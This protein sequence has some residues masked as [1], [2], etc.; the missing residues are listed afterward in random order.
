MQSTFNDFELD[1][2][3]NEPKAKKRCSRRTKIIIGVS[4]A[5]VII[6]IAIVIIIAVSKS[7][8]KKSSSK[9][10]IPE[11]TGENDDDSE[12][13]DKPIDVKISYDKDELRLFNIEQKV[14]S[15]VY[16]ES[17][18]EELISNFKYVC[19]L[20]IK[21]NTNTTIKDD[22]IHEGFFAILSS[23]YHNQT[24]NEDISTQN[25]IQL[26]DIINNRTETPLL[27]IIEEKFYSDISQANSKEKE[28]ENTQPFLKIEFYNNGSYKNIIRPIGLS[29]NNYKQM[30]EFLDIIIPKISNDT[31]INKPFSEKLALL[32]AQRL[33]RLKNNN[34]NKRYLKIRRLNNNN[35]TDNLVVKSN[36]SEDYFD[37]NYE[38]SDERNK[39]DEIEDVNNTAKNKG[40]NT[41][42]IE[43]KKQSLVYMENS[44]IRGS[45]KNSYIHFTLNAENKTNYIFSR[46]FVNLTKQNFLSETDKDIYDSDN[47]LK[48]EDV[49]GQSGHINITNKTKNKYDN[50]EENENITDI[51][52]NINDANSIYSTIDNH[53][54]VNQTYY[55]KKIIDEIYDNYLDKFEYEKSNSTLKILRTLQN[56]LPIKNLSNLEITEMDELS[57]RKLE[58]EENKKY[59]GLKRMSNRKNVFQTN[60]L[61]LDIALGLTNTYIPATG[62]SAIA[63]KLDIGDYKVN[64]QINSFQ[65][66]EPIITE[67]L[68]Q[69][70]FKLLQMMY[71]THLNFDEQNKKYCQ[72]IDSNIKDLLGNELIS[73]NKLGNKYTEIRDY[74]ELI[75]NNIGSFEK[76]IDYFK[77]NIT[78]INNNLN[79]TDNEINLTNYEMILE[80]YINDYLINVT[81]DLN[82]KI[83]Y[84][85]KLILEIKQIIDK[86]SETDLSINEDFYYIIEQIKFFIK[87]NLENILLN[88][89]NE[90]KT[91]FNS[92]IQ[93]QINKIINLNQLNKLEYI[94]KSNKIIDYLFSS[95]EKEYLLS[96]LTNIKT[97]IQNK[98]EILLNRLNYIYD[99]EIKKSNIYNISSLINNITNVEIIKNY[100]KEFKIV[101]EYF[102]DIEK[103]D[104]TINEIITQNIQNFTNIL[105]NSGNYFYEIISN[106]SLHYH[107]K[108]IEAGKLIKNKIKE[109]KINKDLNIKKFHDKYFEDNMF[110]FYNIT[111]EK[112]ILSEESDKN[113]SSFDIDFINS[114]MNTIL[115]YGKKQIDVNF[116]LA[117]E[118]LYE[119]KSFVDECLDDN[120]CEVE[121]IWDYFVNLFS[122][123]DCDYYLNLDFINRLTNMSSYSYQIVIDKIKSDSFLDKIEKYYYSFKKEIE[124][125]EVKIKQFMIDDYNYSYLKNM[126]LE[127]KF[128]FTN[129]KED[130]L[131]KAEKNLTNYGRNIKD[132]FLFQFYKFNNRKKGFLKGEDHDVEIEGFFWNDEYKCKNRNNYKYLK[133]SSKNI[134]NHLEDDRIYLTN[135]IM[136]KISQYKNYYDKYYQDL[137][138]GIEIKSNEINFD[139]INLYF[140]M[141]EY[142]LEIKNYL[143]NITNNEFITNIINKHQNCLDN[144]ETIIKHLEIL[145][146]TKQNLI[147]KYNNISFIMENENIDEKIEM[148]NY[149][150]YSKEMSLNHFIIFIENFINSNIDLIEYLNNKILNYIEANLNQEENQNETNIIQTEFDK[151]KKMINDSKGEFKDNINNIL[152]YY[153]NISN[154]FNIIYNIKNYSEIYNNI[155]ESNQTDNYENKLISN[156]IKGMKIHKEI[157]KVSNIIFNT[158][159]SLD[160]NN[161]FFSYVDKNNINM[162]YE[163]VKL[164]IENEA[165]KIMN[166]FVK[167]SLY[168]TQKKFTLDIINE[169]DNFIKDKNFNDTLEEFNN[170]IFKIDG[171][172]S[173]ELEGELNNLYQQLFYLINKSINLNNNKN[174][175]NLENENKTYYI[176][177]LNFINKV[178]IEGLN[179]R[180]LDDNN[181]SE[182]KEILFVL[183]KRF[184][185]KKINKIKSYLNYSITELYD[186]YKKTDLIS[187]YIDIYKEII[188]NNNELNNIDFSK[189]KIS[190]GGIKQLILD[191]Y[192][193]NYAEFKKN[194]IYDVDLYNKNDSELISN[195][196]NE[197]IDN[198]L[199]KI[200]NVI[201]ISIHESNN[202]KL[203]GY[204]LKKHILSKFDMLI[205][206]NFSIDN[207]IIDDFIKY[208]NFRMEYLEFINEKI[209]SDKMNSIL[210]NNFETSLIDYWKYIFKPTKLEQNSLDI[211]YYTSSMINYTNTLITVN[212]SIYDY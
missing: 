84:I 79:N 136:E 97:F 105:Y 110:K 196:L 88:T 189:N 42:E 1:K 121:S 72:E 27:K 163:Q 171:N 188:N 119:G 129:V 145:N 87:N 91:I 157:N 36:N 46:T 192:N 147:E 205:D 168:E 66:N 75:S 187:S 211:N 109:I 207:K 120:D 82:E 38:F 51:I 194:Y 95:K 44:K 174:E 161:N 172:I 29:E 59:Y 56:I 165:E 14:F 32:R 93:G 183:F 114:I 58:E 117:Y 98:K 180:N 201:E 178:D 154:S 135:N 37:I 78:N 139:L 48:E 160:K 181:E 108:I 16:K 61:G 142:A 11:D 149:L 124:N 90:K 116:N 111:N 34:N 166:I 134:Y 151:I 8:K 25:N 206:S 127:L 13:D 49:M 212:L 45:T 85:N 20:G 10:S 92:M 39:E 73:N 156:Y 80:D 199:N 197:E 86:N 173:S 33:Q 210:I 50:L 202:M 63:F 176:K 162:F 182:N 141:N 115:I 30:K 26:T 184:K 203:D 186:E 21:N 100:S 53:I 41:K 123:C 40:N 137:I 113:F 69:M 138:S 71:L 83:N 6:G 177:I 125:V 158:E 104:K 15:I 94:F 146:T 12:K 204:F 131:N 150:N 81:K 107:K 190:I 28:E 31:F 126:K 191:L 148:I 57:I 65:T 140:I 133:D 152:N 74:Y 169:T 70:S 4:I 5:A 18:S 101:T 143:N 17:G 170:I 208:N 195:L 3:R 155:N 43:L 96:N 68:Q 76:E 167:P 2:I 112:I 200:K 102:E 193:K 24:T 198:I 99:N 153:S 128:N 62:H 35:N 7:G 130:I 54:Y 132:E 22:S 122:N 159:L 144:N 47:Y 77:N 89:L 185:E 103:I 60:F 106:N 19:V 23:I 52:Y 209:Y 179:I 9:P 164:D 67:N 55:N 118:Y 64:H 175:I